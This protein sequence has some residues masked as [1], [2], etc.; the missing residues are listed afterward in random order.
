MIL[1]LAQNLLTLDVSQ[2]LNKINMLALTPLII[3]SIIINCCSSALDIPTVTLLSVPDLIAGDQYVMVCTVIVDEYLV[4]IPT[5]EWRFPDNNTSMSTSPQSTDG[6]SSNITLTF[7]HVRTSQGGIYGCRATINISGF[8]VL[9]Q[10]INETIQ[11]QS[12]GC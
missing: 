11:V 1:S 6:V 9:S 7:N 2:L 4:A 8:D 12:K 10:T 5:L 3:I